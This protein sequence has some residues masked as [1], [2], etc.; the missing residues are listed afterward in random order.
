MIRRPA[1]VA[2][3]ATALALILAGAF[4]LPAAARADEAAN[5]ALWKRYWMAIYAEEQCNNVAFSQAQ[6]DAMVHVINQKIG[7]SVGAGDRTMIMSDAKSEVFDLAF[8]Y[9]CNG[10]DV[11]DLLNLYNKDLAPVV[12]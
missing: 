7:Y 12:K 2:P 11:A 3:G 1:F 9:G 6:Y 5:Q 10:S 8:K 4:G